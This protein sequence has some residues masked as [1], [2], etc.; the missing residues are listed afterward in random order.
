MDLASHHLETLCQELCE[1]TA[2]IC[3]NALD[4]P[5]PPLQAINHTIPLID[6]TK[7][8]P[9]CPSKCPAPLCPLWQAKWQA[10]LDTGCW[11]IA[12]G[13]NAMPMLMLQK[14]GKVGEP[15]QLCTV[16]DSHARNANTC[17][18]ASPLPDIDGILHNV[19][20]HPYRS[21]IDGK[22]A[23]EQIR[24]SPEHVP[25]VGIFVRQEVARLRAPNCRT[26]KNMF[27]NE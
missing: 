4:T 24:V 26:T 21:L 17:K 9:W 3:K 27:Y 13:I 6:N 2:D 20:M 5:L 25:C 23:Y 14:R 10:Y 15:L 1:Y 18:L 11:R 8:Y 7:I 16:I 12:S 19:A 22:D